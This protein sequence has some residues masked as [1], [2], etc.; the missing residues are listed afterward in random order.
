MDT[1]ETLPG[2]D[3]SESRT[4]QVQ[5][6]SPGTLNGYRRLFGGRLMEWID[7]VAAVAARRHSNRNVTTAA[8]DSLDF[9]APAYA[10]DTVVL[11][12]EITYTGRTSMEVRV[13]TYVEALDGTRRLINEAY[14]ILVALDENERPTPVP[15]LVCR[16]EAE[17]AEF[18]AGRARS[19][20][21]KRR[22]PGLKPQGFRA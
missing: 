13:R 16:T 15:P 18:E 20:E 4:E 9:T 2:K 3:A 7:V 1:Q 5:I 17:R 12:G 11:V 10:N 21:R 19:A 8:V 14:V 22:R 6:L